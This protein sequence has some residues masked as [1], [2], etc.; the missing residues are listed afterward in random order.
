[1]PVQ[2]PP[3]VWV[4][5]SQAIVRRGMVACL[6]S[7]G[8]CVRGESAR[9]TP[10]PKVDDL[11]V[12]VFEVHGTSLRQV[13]RHVGEAGTHLVATVRT[14]DERQVRELVESGVAAV[15]LHSELTPE[16]LGATV[17]AVVAG[18]AALPRYLLP[19]LLVLAAQS[20][21]A[22]ST[23]LNPR[24]RDVLRLLAEGPRHPGDR[25]RPVLLRAHRQERGARRAHE[26]ELPH[27]CA[28]RGPG[29]A[30]RRDLSG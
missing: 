27:P 24:E 20:S 1:M 4:D 8:F 29:D 17:S 9:L 5:D 15:L 12:L 13:K 28:R 23:G 25:G 7:Q 30:R 21:G 22:G 11:Q 19:R 14:S 26:D 3:T 16:T 10:L 18:R 2:T 6:T